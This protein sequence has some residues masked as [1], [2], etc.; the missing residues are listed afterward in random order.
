MS[1]RHS[2][3]PVPPAGSSRPSSSTATGGR[4]PSTRRARAASRSSS[5]TSPRPTAAPTTPSRRR[6]A[7]SSPSWATARTGVVRRVL[8]E[9][10][11]AE[12]TDRRDAGPAPLTQRRQ[13]RLRLRPGVRAARLRCRAGPLGPVQRAGERERP[14]EPGVLLVLR[15]PV[16]PRVPAVRPPPARR[17]PRPPGGSWESPA[18]SRRHCRRSPR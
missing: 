11:T 1:R 3:G 14:G 7:P 10:R 9:E 8:D 6:W 17:P 15:S 12:T 2:V 5:G 18:T 4:P 16:G 13:P